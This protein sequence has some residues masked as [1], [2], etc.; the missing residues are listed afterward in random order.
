MFQNLH[1]WFYGDI[2][3]NIWQK[4]NYN[5]LQH[6]TQNADK[7]QKSTI[8]DVYLSNFGQ[9]GSNLHQNM[10]FVYLKGELNI[11]FATVLM[12]FVSLELKDH[13]FCWSQSER[14]LHNYE[15]VQVGLWDEPDQQHAKVREETRSSRICMISVHSEY[16]DHQ[17]K[18][19]SVSWSEQRS[20]PNQAEHDSCRQWGRNWWLFDCYS[21]QKETCSQTT[22]KT[23]IIEFMLGFHVQSHQVQSK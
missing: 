1:Q 23:V 18:A 3:A 14:M 17:S 9:K 19:G 21:N 8:S 12:Q 4:S 22:H 13:S 2:F 11:L 6:L 16:D 20:G 10:Q 5:F 7:F 15:E